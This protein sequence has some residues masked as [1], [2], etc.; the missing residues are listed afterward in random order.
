MPYS[1]QELIARRLYARSSGR[2]QR[3]ADGFSIGHDPDLCIGIVPIKIVTEEQV[4]AIGFGRLDQPPAIIPR[5]DPLSRDVSDLVP[6]AQWLDGIAQ[7]ILAG[8][9]V[10]LWMPHKA[11][12]ECIDVLGH[13]YVSNPDAPP[14]VQHMG[15]TCRALAA[16]LVMAD[17]PVIACALE[18]LA[19]HFITGQSPAEDRHLGSIL[20]WIDPPHGVDVVEAAHRAALLPAAAILPNIPG[21][22][23]DAE[24]ERLRR[25]AKRSSGA[26]QA[27][28]HSRMRNVLESAVQREWAL[29][30][31][32]R[33]HLLAL[34]ATS[35]MPE[36]ATE[37]SL[38]RVRHRIGGGPFRVVQP[39]AVAIEL[40][41]HEGAS[42]SA[43]R[44]VWRHDPR[45]RA[46]AIR[47]G[48]LIEGSLQAITAATGRG[49]R[50]LVTIMTLQRLIRFRAGD[51]LHLLDSTTN[52]VG[53]LIAVRNGTRPGE[54]LVDLEIEEGVRSVSRLS[55]G[56]ATV[57]E[58]RDVNLI[59]REAKMAGQIRDRAP[60]LINDVAPPAANSA[61][62][63]AGDLVSMAS[64]LERIP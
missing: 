4:Q 43:E 20:T 19:Q 15:R 53:R 21:Q 14:I 13:R 11:A 29:M 52:F 60:W 26:A 1:E 63:P 31:A 8:N 9:K 27:A 36:D 32:G 61:A 48:K 18:L 56:N 54:R 7:A 49:T 38:E 55:L 51:K 59:M 57:W 62:L 45:R 22:M 64:A 30:M 5:M 24:V 3:L 2:A 42:N 34:P 41:K 16:E 10:R 40:R 25:E 28:A 12:L 33:R 50:P 47:R 6:F 58:P 46:A 35:P 44:R 37:A 17:Q 23:D 39:H